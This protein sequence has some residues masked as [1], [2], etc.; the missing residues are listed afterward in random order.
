MIV[1]EAFLVFYPNL[2]FKYE[3]MLDVIIPWDILVDLKVMKPLKLMKKLIPY[4]HEEGILMK[5]EVEIG[6]F[7]A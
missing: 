1:F 4:F 3:L 6:R 2:S 5:F 7:V